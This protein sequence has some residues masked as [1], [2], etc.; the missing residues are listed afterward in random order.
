MINQ[1]TNLVQWKNLT[2]DEKAAFDFENYKYEHQLESETEW[3]DSSG[4]FAD[5]VYRLVIEPDKW[6][7]CGDINGCDILLGEDVI[8]IAD[9]ELRPA[10]KAEIASVSEIPQSETLEDCVKA[11]LIDNWE[12]LERWVNDINNYEPNQIGEYS[13]FRVDRFKDIMKDIK[14]VRDE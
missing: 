3:I 4:P 12:K 6:Y 8:V 13:Y 5:D 2:D 11:E 1:V 7:Y 10:T 14:A 9:T